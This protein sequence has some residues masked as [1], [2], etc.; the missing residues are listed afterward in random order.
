M[1]KSLIASWAACRLPPGMEVLFLVLENGP[2]GTFDLSCAPAG[3]QIRHMVEPRMGIP[4]A[5]NAAVRAALGWGADLIAFVDDD[6]IVTESWLTELVAEQKSSGALL[7][8]GPIEAIAAEIPKTF[9]RVTIFNG[10]HRRTLR[11]ACIST[12]RKETGRMDRVT[13]VTSNWLA[14]RDLFDKHDI[15]FDE[16]YAVSG[17]SDA[18]FSAE[19]TRRRLKKSWTPAAL[20]YEAIPLSRM[21]FRYQFRRGRDQSIVSIQRK[22]EEWPARVVVLTLPSVLVRALGVGILVFG[23]PFTAV[24]IARGSGWVVGRL[25]GLA[26]VKSRLYETVTGK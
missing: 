21:S 8:G 20:V 6:E 26:G 23:F 2:R 14:H 10:I 5:R 17:G 25:L 11:K 18:A 15:W 16:R 9:W 3:L 19:V 1:L 13:I 24:S 12:R 4:F 22:L 7:V